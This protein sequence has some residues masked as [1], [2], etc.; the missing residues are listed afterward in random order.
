MQKLILPFK[1]S[2]LES[3]AL[4]PQYK[5]YWGYNHY[6]WDLTGQRR[7]VEEDVY[8]S[9]I[10]KVIACG[11]DSKVGYVAVIQYFDVYNHL[12]G[13]VCDVIARY[14]HMS[15]L[16]IQTGQPVDTQT[17]IGLMS[18]YGIKPTS[19]DIHLHIEFDTDI[20]YPCYS[21]SVA[22]GSIIRKGTATTMINP[23]EIFHIGRNQVF[24]R[25]SNSWYTP[26]DM[27]LPRWTASEVEETKPSAQYLIQPVNKTILSAGYMNTK[28]KNKFGFQHYGHDVYSGSGDLTVY[29]SG[30]GEVI[31]CGYD[32]TL[33]NVV[34][35]RYNN[36]YNEK[37]KKAQ[38][39]IMRYYHLAS[40]SV[41]KKATVNKDTKLG[42]MGSTGKYSLGIHLH[43]EI[44]T[45]TDYP[46][47]SPTVGT[48]GTLI[49]A[50]TPTTVN[51]A[52]F[53]HTKASAPDNQTM[54]YLNDGYSGAEDKKYTKIK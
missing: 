45:D 53:I 48:S 42:V 40:I 32:S 38:D 10:G 19:Y 35:V 23:N 7:K 5:A 51:P 29:A 15:R 2:Y 39:V 13:E 30:N 36:A 49:K 22:G 12:T 18:G 46:C 1:I 11:K 37:T 21:G 31:E 26:R 14:F 25:Y 41:N 52:Y 9:G 24:Y 44:D 8:A 47:Y 33:G 16:Y 34:V 6:G 54:N 20:Q 17:R 4:V 50:G 3:G 43:Y 28:Y 27:A